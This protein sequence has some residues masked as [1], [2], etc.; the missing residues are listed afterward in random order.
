MELLRERDDLIGSMWIH[1]FCWYPFWGWFHGKL[2]GT[3]LFVGGNFDTHPMSSRRGA[4][5]K[6]PLKLSQDP[7]LH[8]LVGHGKAAGCGELS[9]D[10]RGR[11]R[12]LLKCRGFR[13]FGRGDVGMGGGQ[14]LGLWLVRPHCVSGGVGRC[15]LEEGVTIARPR[16][17]GRIHAKLAT[18]R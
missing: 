5:S 17:T 15:M 1:V 10:H 13:R 6:F 9:C 4:P 16:P 12:W 7:S 18:G 14:G 8:G 2:E 3:A 11:R